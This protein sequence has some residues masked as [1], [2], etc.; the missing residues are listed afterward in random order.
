M[1]DTPPPEGVLAATARQECRD[2]GVL[3]DGLVVKTV[4]NFLQRRLLSRGSSA[5]WY[6]GRG[7]TSNET[8]Q[9]GA[10]EPEGK[11]L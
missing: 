1:R 9:C 11:W 8:E 2:R 7:R 10:R 5:P 3:L 4:A 6:A